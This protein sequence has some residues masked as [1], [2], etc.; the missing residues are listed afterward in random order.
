MEGHTIAEVSGALERGRVLADRGL[1]DAALEEWQG[2]VSEGADA[3][4]QVKALNAMASVHHRRQD[5]I[6]AFACTTQAWARAGAVEAT[7][8]VTAVRAV[9]NHAVNLALLGRFAESEA[10][11]ASALELSAA[12][13]VPRDE[14]ARVLCRRGVLAVELGRHDEAFVYLTQ[15]YRVF[16]AR[17]DRFWESLAQQHLAACERGMGQPDVA[18]RRLVRGSAAVL[19]LEDDRLLLGFA[20]DVA[21]TAFMTGEDARAVKWLAV[22]V[23]VLCEAPVLV[24]VM[25]L[26]RAEGLMAVLWSSQGH[27]REAGL[28]LSRSER[29]LSVWGRRTEWQVLRELGEFKRA[30]AGAGSVDVQLL[31]ERIE[32][33][34]RYVEPGDHMAAPPARGRRLAHYAHDVGPRIAPGEVRRAVMEECAL[35]S[36]PFH[37]RYLPAEYDTLE[38]LEAYASGVTTEGYGRTLRRILGS[39]SHLNSDIARRLMELHS[40]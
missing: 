20:T 26:G 36:G 28:M 22:A 35:G 2:V 13:R 17:G 9:A 33:L 39:S 14:R 23:R 29:H 3:G 19:E 31:G 11:F 40:A 37:V 7:D 27:D 12:D 30:H 10:C 38:V 18:L 1:L 15:A 16:R 25:E 8:P 32:R 24:D 6:A 4:A 5:V 21:L 34:A